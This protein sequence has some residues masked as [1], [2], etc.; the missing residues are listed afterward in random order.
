[1]AG[2]FFVHTPEGDSYIVMYH[3]GKD[4]IKG[5]KLPHFNKEGI[6][7]LKVTTKIIEHIST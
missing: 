5:L 7:V 2:S 4:K 3:V 1:M 6:V